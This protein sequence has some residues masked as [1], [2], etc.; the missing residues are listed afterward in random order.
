[1]AAFLQLWFL[2]D[3]ASSFWL[4]RSHNAVLEPT[5]GS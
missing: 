3:V 1:M 4:A 5:D 2:L